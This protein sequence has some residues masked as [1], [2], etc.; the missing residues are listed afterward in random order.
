MHKCSHGTILPSGLLGSV[1]PKEVY[2]W[3]LT[4]QHM[5]YIV[6]IVDCTHVDKNN[7][8]LHKSL[9]LSFHRYTQVK[10]ILLH[11]AVSYI[12]RWFSFAHLFLRTT[13]FSV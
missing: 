1:D 2:E 9:L 4:H 6:A 7:I 5:P 12:A 10:Q 13:R 8:I 3:S 11:Q